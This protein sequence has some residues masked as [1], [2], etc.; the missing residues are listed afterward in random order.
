MLIGLGNRSSNLEQILWKAHTYQGIG[1]KSI[2]QKFKSL[3]I[4]W[5]LGFNV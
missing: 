5:N 1:R 4:Q 2:L 3:P